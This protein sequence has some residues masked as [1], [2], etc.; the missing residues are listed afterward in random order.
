MTQPHS[1]IVKSRD[2]ER[3]RV[4]NEILRMGSMAAAQLAA[5][6]DVLERHDDKAAEGLIRNDGAIDKLERQNNLDA[7]TLWMRGPLACAL[8]DIPTTLSHDGHIAL[9]TT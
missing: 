2:E 4:I 9:W 7:M 8:L 6:L 5:A 3:N 1:H